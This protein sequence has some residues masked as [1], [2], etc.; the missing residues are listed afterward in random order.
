[1]SILKVEGPLLTCTITGSAHSGITQCL[2]STMLQASFDQDMTKFEELSGAPTPDGTA[3]EVSEA[4]PPQEDGR[5]PT[6]YEEAEA[7]LEAHVMDVWY[8]DLHDEKELLE[9]TPPQRGFLPN[10][11]HPRN[12]D[13]VET[14]HVP[15]CSMVEDCSYGVDSDEHGQSV[16]LCFTADMS[17][18]VLSEQQHWISDADRVTTMR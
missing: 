5:V 4:E 3:R 7:D 13:I 1:M 8:T 14:Y 16:E 11:G 6:S 17:K 15:L 10:W 2:K 12:S 9:A 18:V